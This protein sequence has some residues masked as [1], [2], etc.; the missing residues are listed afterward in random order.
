MAEDADNLEGM[1]VNE[2]LFNLGLMEAFDE[3]VR[4]GKL[5]A[6]LAVLQSAKFSDSQAQYTATTILANPKRYGY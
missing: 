1:T 2:R 4:S 6:V 5:E 3:A